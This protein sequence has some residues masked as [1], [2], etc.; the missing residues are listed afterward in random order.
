M[1]ATSR[2]SRPEPRIRAAAIVA[3]LLLLLALGCTRGMPPDPARAL[4]RREPFK[5][6]RTVASSSGLVVCADAEAARIGARVLAEGGNAVD[7]AVAVAF[8]LAV[9]HPQAGNLGGGGFMLVRRPDGSVDAVDYRETAPAAFHPEVYLGTDGEIDRTRYDNPY[10]QVGVPGTVAGLAL[11]HRRH[12]RRPFHLLVEPAERLA[13]A[14]FIVSPLLARDLRLH[15]AK[16]S[17]HPSTVRVFFHWDREPYQAGERLQQ[18]ELAGVLKSIAT[19]G[20]DVFYRGWIGEAIAQK[21]RAGGGCLTAADFRRYEARLRDPIRTPLRGGELI[22]MPP[23]SSGGIAV[24]QV[25]A[26]LDSP[27]LHRA[28]PVGPQL[29]HALAES[30]RRA[31]RDRALHLGDP[32]F[33]AVPVNQLLSAA[34]VKELRGGIDPRRATPSESLWPVPLPLPEAGGETTHF[35]VL[36]RDGMA[37]AN[38][39]TL[40]QTFGGGVVAADLGIFLNNELGDFNPKPGDTDRAGRIGTPPNLP[41]AGKRPLSSMSPAIYVRDGQ[42]EIITGSPGGRTIISTVAGVL[43]K[44]LFLELDPEHAVWSPRLH[45]AWLPDRLELEEGL[46]PPQTLE[47]LRALGHTVKTASSQGAAHSIFRDGERGYVG[48]GDCRGDG[49]AAAPTWFDGDEER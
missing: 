47:V 15:R 17:R 8:A 21:V 45:H 39:Y 4:L 1:L 43:L 46:W 42:V 31:F 23:P 2:I 30:L 32:D 37:V 20:T 5:L 10:L 19:G 38:T 25:L 11:A 48:V 29:A 6:G 9:T 35:S 24:A 27:A 33:T 3:A 44:R 18:P 41:A 14:G 13:R 22:G 34:H 26:I 28:D 40:E 36:D 7:A 12:G 16:L 49:W